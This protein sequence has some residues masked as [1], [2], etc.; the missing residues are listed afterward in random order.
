[1]AKGNM[2]NITIEPMKN[3]H[4]SKS[5]TRLKQT[6]TNDPSIYSSLPYCVIANNGLEL[7]RNRKTKQVEQ[8]QYLRVVCHYTEFS[9]AKLRAQIIL[10]SNILRLLDLRGKFIVVSYSPQSHDIKYS[11]EFS[12]YSKNIS[13]ILSLRSILVPDSV[14]STSSVVALKFRLIIIKCRYFIEY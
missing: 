4:G 7:F 11:T 9:S 6:N 8:N 5:S 1:M 13:G 12:T 2:K 3:R 14:L 10:M